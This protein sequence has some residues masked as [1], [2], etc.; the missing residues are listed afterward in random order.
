MSWHELFI[1]AREA[2]RA[3]DFVLA[4]KK[5]RQALEFAER[6][7]I[8]PSFAVRAIWQLAELMNGQGLFAEGERLLRRG[9]GMVEESDGAESPA[10]ASWLFAL[11]FSFIQQ[12]R[13]AEADEVIRRS[14]AIRQRRCGSDHPDC[15]LSLGALSLVQSRI[16]NCGQAEVIEG[17]ALRISGKA[18]A[19]TSG[20]EVARLLARMRAHAGDDEP[21]ARCGRDPG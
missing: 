14:L 19:Q 18:Q 12:K 15:A 3:C 6:T 21:V 1:S 2:E 8:D 4:E 9:L 20:A 16:G 7:A 10:A 13:Y 11:G 5:Y 17:E